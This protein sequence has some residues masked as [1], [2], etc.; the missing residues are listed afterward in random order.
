MINPTDGHQNVIWFL[1]KMFE[2]FERGA[3]PIEK[4]QRYEMLELDYNPNDKEEIRF[5]YEYV[6]AV[7][8]EDEELNFIEIKGLSDMDIELIADNI[9][10]EEDE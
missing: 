5:Y 7:S 6:E 9:N 3:I 10:L 2:K 1:Q 8:L 4:Y